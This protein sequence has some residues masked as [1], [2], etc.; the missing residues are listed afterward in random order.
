MGSLADANRVPQAASG[1]FT[2]IKQWFF[3]DAASC[4]NETP[5]DCAPIGC[6]YDGQVRFQATTCWLVCCCACILVIVLV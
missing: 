6:R 4:L 2:P 3:L 5:T 1:K